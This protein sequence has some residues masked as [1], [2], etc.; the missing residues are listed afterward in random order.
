MYELEAESV[1]P[2]TQPA[3]NPDRVYLH[4]ECRFYCLQWAHTSMME[5]AGYLRTGTHNNQIL[6]PV[7][8]RPISWQTVI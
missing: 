6:T 4:G 3:M 1:F 2:C 5:A 8:V 7:H